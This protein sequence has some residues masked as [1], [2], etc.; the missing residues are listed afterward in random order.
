MAY[1]VA[2]RAYVESGMMTKAHSPAGY[3][4]ENDI[5]EQ[6]MFLAPTGKFVRRLR[7]EIILGYYQKYNKPVGKLRI[8]TL[9]SLALECYR[10]LPENFRKIILSDSYQMALFEEAATNAGL[11]FF[12]GKD[13]SLAPH[14]MK[15][16]VSIING[17][18]EDGITPANL[19]EDLDNPGEGT[20]IPKLGDIA[21]LY[22]SYKALQGDRFTDSYNI[23][24]ELNRYLG[25]KNGTL[26]FDSAGNHA[27]KFFEG[28]KYVYL[29][30]FTEFRP[31]ETE[32]LLNFA[33][34]A[35]PMAIE[36]DYSANNGPLF[37]HMEYNIQ[38]L[39]QGGLLLH[40]LSDKPEI[41]AGVDAAEQQFLRR[42]LFNR[43]CDIRHSSL[44]RNILIMAAKDKLAEVNAICRLVK[45]L[46]S[47][48]ALKPHEICIVSRRPENYAPL[49]RETMPL[50]G[51][52]Y[53]I[54]QR[55]ELSASPVVNA[56]FS[57]LDLCLKGYRLK[58]L[59]KAVRSPYL[60]FKWSAG[61]GDNL[62]DTANLIDVA[63]KM[64]I[65]GGKKRGGKDFWAKRL[66]S[67]IMFL[68][69][70][71]SE[72]QSAEDTDTMET[73]YL[74]AGLKSL[75][76]AAS[77]FNSITQIVP[78]IDSRMT[79]AAFADKIVD[80]II[81][82]FDIAG[83]IEKLYR[84]STEQSSGNANTG[85]A[86]K[87]EKT[88]LDLKAADELIK[89]LDEFVYI[90]NDRF[91][92]KKFDS[93]LLAAKFKTAVL[94][95][96]YQIKEKPGFGVTVTSVEQ[97]RGMA[98]R[99]EIL[100]G[101]V[102]GEF[103]MAYVPEYFLGKELPETEKR[104]LQ[105]ERLQFYN[106]LAGNDCLYENS[107]K[108]IFI[109][110]PKYF[111]TEE[112]VRSPF[113]DELMK[114]SLIEANSCFVDLTEKSNIPSDSGGFSFSWVDSRADNRDLFSEVSRNVKYAK[115]ILPENIELSIQ[116]I[117][118]IDYI[119]RYFS[120]LE[121]IQGEYNGLIDSSA[122]PPELAAGLADIKSRAFSVSELEEYARCPFRYMAN[123][124]MK[125]K[126]A[127]EP[128]E[129]L[130]SLETGNLIHGILNRFI[131]ELQRE[132]AL[133]F[134]G[135]IIA[136]VP[137]LPPMI[138]VNLD[139]E[140]YRRYLEKLLSIAAEELEALRF[141]HPFFDIE[142]KR[143]LGSSYS[144]G[145][146]EK[147][148]IAEINK[149]DNGFRPVLTELSFGLSGWGPSKR[150]AEIG[151]V[152]LGNGLL[153]KGKTDRIELLIRE[154]R[155]FL[156]IADY[157]SGL[158]YIPGINDIINGKAFQMT[159]YLS[160]VAAI[161]RD[162]YGLG[163]VPAGVVYYSYNPEYSEKEKNYKLS[164]FTFFSEEFAADIPGMK[165][166]GI[167]T[168]G[169]IEELLEGSAGQAMK[170][171]EGISGGKFNPLDK[172]SESVC[173]QCPYIG[174]CRIG[175]NDVL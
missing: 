47:E 36:L 26:D 133:S 48:K 132:Q 135:S 142:V 129:F 35:I 150:Q 22:R 93:A 127:E 38:K 162:Y 79:P 92:G 117:S 154:G 94:A 69:S 167:M 169:G 8:F 68:H 27:D 70:R 112:L 4:I 88:E 21:K 42:W 82:K 19:K 131:R 111:G 145:M 170:I 100:C 52:P 17:L 90:L 124:L 106:F 121:S 73:D 125:L 34:S 113:I 123:Y 157:K 65:V 164:E 29:A 72:L 54:T 146:L 39:A 138:Q 37:S 44:H 9:Q 108:S 60:T 160:A 3:A 85:K 53:N 45:Y 109:T 96:K 80:G 103:P 81:K 1:I 6:T 58:D 15:R 31:P 5:A 46:C 173:R 84:K 66:D 11:S 13:A 25:I 115:K 114:I 175:N 77:D 28:I 86:M 159:L 41:S 32:F 97:T 67:V 101:A 24:N 59:Q 116:D 134:L 118:S 89:I 128:E 136:H 107:A 151:A 43:E 75:K 155:Y 171:V 83:N 63:L 12:A 57:V 137:G 141:E 105:A 143:I 10:K 95:Q 49:F 62:P 153:V 149:P 30:G 99:A 40:N 98:F 156:A 104:F 2:N 71:L 139:K 140:Q 168:P 144:P 130:S 74:K 64:R 23:F 158:K 7:N 14:V 148:L 161:L 152:K 166:N 78:E 172:L 76:K 56:V 163:P 61:G 110:Y 87:L 50:Y 20:D 102:D 18:A 91:P 119:K 33:E 16:L 122:L 55:H 51:I 120:A 165:K 174:L 126:K 147:W